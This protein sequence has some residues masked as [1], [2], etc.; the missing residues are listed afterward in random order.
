MAKTLRPRLTDAGV[1]IFFLDD[2][3]APLGLDSWQ[4]ELFSKDFGEFVKGE[5]DFE[6]VL[7]WRVAGAT[8]SFLAVA[9]ARDRGADFPF[10]LADASTVLA[11]VAELGDVDR[12][13]RNGDEF[14]A[15][16]ADHLAV[17]DV[18]AQVGLDLPSDDLLEP[19]RV[20]FDFSDHGFEPF[21]RISRRGGEVSDPFIGRLSIGDRAFHWRAASISLPR[22][23]EG[24]RNDWDS[25]PR[26]RRRLCCV[27]RDFRPEWAKQFS[28]GNAP[29]TLKT[30]SPRRGGTGLGLS[31]WESDRCRS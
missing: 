9:R 28:P 25:V 18:F 8:G 3:G 10:S 23:G 31:K 21:A 30:L 27:L 22:A 6:D 13:E 5:L 20:S 29:G 17:R 7:A 1:F 16:L 24:D 12:G 4:G 2:I 15:G 26:R 14:A 19:V 11:A